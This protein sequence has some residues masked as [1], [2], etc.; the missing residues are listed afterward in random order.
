M[1]VCVCKN[2]TDKDPA[3]R[4]L[5]QEDQEFTVSLGNSLSNIMSSRPGWTALLGKQKQ[6]NVWGEARSEVWRNKFPLNVEGSQQ[7]YSAARPLSVKSVCRQ[8]P[9]KNKM[10]E[11]QSCWESTVFAFATIMSSEWFC[12]HE[13]RSF[14]ISLSPK[15]TWLSLLSYLSPSYIHIP[16]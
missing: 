11:V 6:N 5:I 13:Y 7:N 16:L 4:R 9:Q 3:F 10:S 14:P 2:Q 8:H 12:M 15:H 1:C